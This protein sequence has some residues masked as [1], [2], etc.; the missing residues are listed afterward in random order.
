MDGGIK[1]VTLVALCGLGG[2]ARLVEQRGSD[3]DNHPRG[4]RGL[5]VYRCFLFDE[6]MQ[7]RSRRG[8]GRGQDE[9]QIRVLDNDR[10]TLFELRSVITVSQNSLFR[11][12]TT[13]ITQT[14]VVP[15]IYSNPSFQT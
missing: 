2:I 1:I 5:I 4:A 7:A 12:S 3:E 13:Q 14:L 10:M 9:F 8:N 15:S 6:R 11:L